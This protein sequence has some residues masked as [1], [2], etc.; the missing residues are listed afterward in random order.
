M[1]KRICLT[2]AATLLA[3]VILLSGVALAGSAARAA[4]PAV[5]HSAPTSPPSASDANPQTKP[6]PPTHS[7]PLDVT[8]PGAPI[9]VVVRPSGAYSV[10][11]NGVQQFY[12]GY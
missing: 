11:Y 4:F 8:I 3:L 2:V 10:Y 6:N 5:D 12:G 1:N 9:S 7:T